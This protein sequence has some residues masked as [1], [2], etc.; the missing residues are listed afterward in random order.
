MTTEGYVAKTIN[1]IIQRQIT[2]LAADFTIRLASQPVNTVGTTTD[3]MT[4][5]ELLK[6]VL[7]AYP[8]GYQFSKSYIYPDAKQTKQ[9]HIKAFYYMVSF[10]E[11]G[12]MKMCQCF[13]L[14]TSWIPANIQCAQ[15]Y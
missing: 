14:R 11:S 1:E 5:Y 6:L 12:N 8:F 3:L 10:R 2:V 13:P 9:K 4:V 15:R 7:D